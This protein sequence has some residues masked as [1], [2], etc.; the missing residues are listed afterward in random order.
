MNDRVCGWFELD[1]AFMFFITDE[2][3]WRGTAELFGIEV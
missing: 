2:K 1:N 3:M